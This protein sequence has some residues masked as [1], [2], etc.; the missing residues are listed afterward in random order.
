MSKG[1]SIAKRRGANPF[2]IAVHKSD[3]VEVL[4]ALGCTVQLGSDFSSESGGGSQAAYQIQSV[5]VVFSDV[6][7]DVSVC[8]PL[9]HGDE[10]SLF[11]V[12]L[13]PNEL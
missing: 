1:E 13:N 3:T 10:L 9:C 2:E 5:G 8:H 4:Q 6:L 11:Y 12:L 7:N